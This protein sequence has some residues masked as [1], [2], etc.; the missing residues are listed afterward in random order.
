MGRQIVLR[1]SEIRIVEAFKYPSRL[2]DEDI[3]EMQRRVLVENKK[4]KLRKSRQENAG[5]S[6]EK[7]AERQR[8]Y[9]T[10]RR[11][12]TW[13]SPIPAGMAIWD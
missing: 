5:G 2:T 7:E 13:G 10:G 1:Y 12:S 4:W 8:Q 3:A 11:K 6:D 9:S